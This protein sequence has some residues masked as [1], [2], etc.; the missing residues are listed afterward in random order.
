MQMIIFYSYTQLPKG[1]LK[2]STWS[3]SR[4]YVSETPYG[5]EHVGLPIPTSRL[6]ETVLQ[7]GLSSASST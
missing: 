3:I 6:V 2:L 4:V 1:Q 7:L 5:M